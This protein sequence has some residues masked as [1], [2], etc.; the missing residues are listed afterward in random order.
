M[1]FFFSTETKSDKLK[2]TK[3][4]L[5]FISFK[6]KKNANKNND[7]NNNNNLMWHLY[8]FHLPCFTAEE[9]FIISPTIMAHVWKICFCIYYRWEEGIME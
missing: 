9:N 2:W 1:L 3:I 4:E 6:N 8:D 5:N 7:N